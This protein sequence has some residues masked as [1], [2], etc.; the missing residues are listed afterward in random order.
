MPAARAGHRQEGLM[1]FRSESTISHPREAVFAAYR[2]RLPEVVSY[3]E[4]ISAVNVL[5]REEA[6]A[7]VKLHNE[8]VSSREIPKIAQSILKPEHLRWDDHA[9]WDGAAWRCSFEIKTRAFRENV[10]CTGTN[11]FLVQGAGTKVVLEGEFSV[12]LKDVPGVPWMLA[13]TIVP[14]I[15]KFI[16][17][18][19]QPNLEKVNQALGKFLDAGG[20]S[21]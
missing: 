1:K 15:E 16:I 5:Q 6:G 8:W 14:Q 13:G 20:R 2:D 17:A 19:I 9:A 21:A 7:V 11:T 3:L 4:D 12:S 10:R 18:L